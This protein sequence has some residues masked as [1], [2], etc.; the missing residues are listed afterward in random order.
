[1]YY[2]IV[3]FV[4]GAHVDVAHVDE[5]MPTPTKTTCCSEIDQIRNKRGVS[6]DCISIH[7]GFWT[8]CLD[9]R[10]LQTAYFNL[11]QHYGSNA[12]H[13][14]INQYAAQLFLLSCF[15]VHTLGNID[16]SYR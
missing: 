15:Y 11:R 2:T 13:G 10:V 5:A 12:P 8:V 4:P 16:T 1:M 7:P 14:T 3:I 9:V 6:V